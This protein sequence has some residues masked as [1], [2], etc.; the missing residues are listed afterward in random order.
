MA[1]SS[2]QAKPSQVGR[3]PVLWQG[4]C[5]DIWSLKG[6][7]PQKLSSR[8]L[9]GVL[10]LLAQVTRYWHRLEGACDPGQAGFSASLMLSQVPHDW[11][12]TEVVVLRSSGESSRDLGR[13]H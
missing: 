11:V 2:T 8:H 13:V 6:G 3:T 5:P 12:G 4:R 1:S 10:Q 9:G 7:L